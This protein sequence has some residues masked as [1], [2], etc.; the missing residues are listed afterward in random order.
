MD[1][2]KF[3]MFYDIQNVIVDAYICYN[4][5][6]TYHIMNRTANPYLRTARVAVIYSSAQLNGDLDEVANYLGLHITANQGD[7][8]AYLGLGLVNRYFKPSIGDS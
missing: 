1:C 4:A 6:Q 3:F 5:C 2:A 8:N 7:H